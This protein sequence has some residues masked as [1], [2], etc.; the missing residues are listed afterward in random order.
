MR[1]ALLALAIM[2]ALALAAVPAA[3]DVESEVNARFRGRAVVVAAGIASSCDGFYNDNVV[4]GAFLDSKAR[5]RFEPGELARVERVSVKRSRVD[6]FLDLAH[7]VLEPRREGPFT[8]YDERWCKVQLQVPVPAHAG[9]P[10]IEAALSRLLERHETVAQAEASPQWNRR[11]REP[12]PEDYEETLADYE[13]WKASEVNAAVQA[14][15]DD[16]I[17][18]AARATDRMR[19]DPD[20]LAGFAAGAEK[21]RG[22]WLGDCESLVSATFYPESE[23][24]GKS[25]DWRRGH[26]DGQRLAWNVALLDRLRGCF[27]PVPR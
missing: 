13:I 1:S 9:L 15:I 24:S 16:A 22:R 27:V 6:V 3:A 4:R 5:R 19:S 23:G 10:E 11:R 8:L 25:S 26:E 21:V 18:E 20:Y 7:A 12:Y 17:E 14:R 2:P